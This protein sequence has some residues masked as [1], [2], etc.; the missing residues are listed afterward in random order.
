LAT[1]SRTEKGT[2]LIFGEI[3]DEK[4]DAALFLFTTVDGLP[5][6]YVDSHACYYYQYDVFGRVTSETVYGG[7]RTESYTYTEGSDAAQNTDPTADNFGAYNLNVWTTRTVEHCADGSTY[8]VYS[9]YFC[10]T[11]L[12]DLYDP[13]NAADPHAYTYY[14]YDYYGDVTVEA[15]SSAIAGY[16]DGGA[17]GAI[18]LVLPTNV[19]SVSLR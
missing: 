18:E 12:D 17:S 11:I 7:L 19:S 16:N 15:P 10:Q 4:G 13:A 1:P 3:R 2:S 8:T 9:N 14:Q 6:S 5:A